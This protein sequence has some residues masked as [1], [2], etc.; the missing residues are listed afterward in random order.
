MDEIQ[1]VLRQGTNPRPSTDHRGCVCLSGSVAGR[2]I[3]VVINPVEKVVLTVW[4]D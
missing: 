4:H 1:A 3:T 2:T